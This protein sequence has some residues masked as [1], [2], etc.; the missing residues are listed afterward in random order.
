MQSLRLAFYS[1]LVVTTAFMV[2]AILNA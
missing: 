1:F 2:I